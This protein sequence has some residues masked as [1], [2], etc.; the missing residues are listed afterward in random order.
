MSTPTDTRERRIRRLI[1]TFELA[2]I[3]ISREQAERAVDA[4]AKEPLPDFSEELCVNDC[5]DCP[6]A[7]ECER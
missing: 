5:S 4:A 6:E 3:P 7:Q 1:S 2:G